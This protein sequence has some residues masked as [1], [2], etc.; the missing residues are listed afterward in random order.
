[1]ATIKIRGR[2]SECCVEHTVS[3]SKCNCCW[4]WWWCWWRQMM[5]ES[6][7]RSN[8]GRLTKSGANTDKQCRCWYWWP[9]LLLLSRWW[10]NK[11][12]HWASE[13]VNRHRITVI[14]DAVSDE[15]RL[16]RMSERIDR[17]RGWGDK[18]T[19][20]SVE[21]RLT[22][23]AWTRVRAECLWEKRREAMRFSRSERICCCR[24]GC[25]RE[26]RAAED[27]KCSWRCARR[28]DRHFSCADSSQFF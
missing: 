8:L 16:K 13:T 19:S 23:C 27:R 21:V 5:K 20:H 17:E 4:G 10:G 12:G 9:L 3:E 7:T 14:A 24:F 2:E 6:S 25:F 28:E 15:R 1:M 18:E 26:V 11:D 22:R